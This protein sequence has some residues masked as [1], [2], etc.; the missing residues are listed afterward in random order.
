[1]PDMQEFQKLKPKNMVQQ[2]CQS[3]DIKILRDGTWLHEGRPIKRMALVKLFS[4]VLKCDRAGQHWLETPVEKGTI[5]VEDSAFV[6]KY[7][8]ISGTGP[9]QNIEFTTN[10]DQNIHLGKDADLHLKDNIPY[11]TLDKGL[12]ARIIRPHFYDLAEQAMTEDNQCYLYS[13]GK[14]FLLGT[15]AP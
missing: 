7:M 15:L 11:L 5:E 13:A 8:T 6:T 4:T 9:Q 10:I 1:M 2:N 3:F 14:K 12:T